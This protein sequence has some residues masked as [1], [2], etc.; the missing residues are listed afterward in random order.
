MKKLILFTTFIL[1]FVFTVFGQNSET[2]MSEKESV[3][4]ASQVLESQPFHEKAKDFRSFA[5]G[6]VIET[7]DVNIIVCG[8]K[9]MEAILDK[10]NKYGSELTAQYTIAMAAFK[11]SNPDNKNENDAQYAGLVSATKTYENI[12]KDKPKAK[13]AGMDDLVI[14]REN[15]ELRKMVDAA[16]CGK[17]EDK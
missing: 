8:G 6:Y 15:G 3:I 16:N 2:K 4:K 13:H 9:M 14:K 5:V 10:K 1:I 11:L 7:K 17:K 12:V